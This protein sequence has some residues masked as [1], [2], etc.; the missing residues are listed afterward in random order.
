[1]DDLAIDDVVEHLQVRNVER[2]DRLDRYRKDVVSGA[3]RCRLPHF[4]ACLSQRPQD[5]GTVEPLTLA[6]IAETH[7]VPSVL[8]A[9]PRRK[10][11]GACRARGAR[12]LRFESGAAN[13]LRRALTPLDWP[14]P[15]EKDGHSLPER[16]HAWRII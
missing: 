8:A 16:A 4:G 10:S 13:G 3:R 14:R 1:M 12:P 6:M 7:D 15:V 9:R 5:L 11:R 2:A